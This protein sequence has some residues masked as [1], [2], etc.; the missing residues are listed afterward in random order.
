MGPSTWSQQPPAGVRRVDVH[1]PGH[2]DHGH[3]R[4]FS[5]TIHFGRVSQD[6]NLNKETVVVMSE[7]TLHHET[8]AGFALT[9]SGQATAQCPTPPQLMQ[10]GSFID[11]PIPGAWSAM[12]DDRVPRLS[13]WRTA[14]AQ[15]QK[16][17]S[18][19]VLGGVARP[20]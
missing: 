20:R 6:S 2:G 14:L 7:K 17:G 18:M 9:G 8:Y 4:Y 13:G 16:G 1:H 12:V 3:S 10:L 15:A 11:G 5:G 19:R